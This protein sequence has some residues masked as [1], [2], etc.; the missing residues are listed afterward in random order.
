MNYRSR[1]YDG[2][3]TRSRWD[4]DPYRPID[5]CDPPI[6]WPRRPSNFPGI[7]LS[8]P[9]PWMFPVVP[10][11]GGWGTIRLSAEGPEA[12]RRP[13]M[14]R[15]RYCEPYYTR[16]ERCCERCGCSPC[17]CCERCGWYPC[18]CERCDRC[19]YYECRC[20]RCD[21]CGCSPCRCGKYYR[22]RRVEVYVDSPPGVNSKVKLSEEWLPR[23]ASPRV[24]PFNPVDSAAAGFTLNANVY[25][26][27]DVFRITV[28]VTDGSPPQT[29]A[30]FLA[31]VQD[32]ANLEIL[33]CLIVTLY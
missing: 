6:S 7:S 22:W 20:E 30:H 10:W 5:R 15:D 18:R 33:A 1:R 4:S 14:D 21:K 32:K 19:G 16:Y 11:L 28:K 3:C 12:D 31:A 2:Y 13:A 24:G 9:M 17:R 8:W 29:P 25:T 26:S 27:G 23:E